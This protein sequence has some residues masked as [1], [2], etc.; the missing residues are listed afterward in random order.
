MKMLVAATFRSYPENT[1]LSFVGRLMQRC[2]RAG[3]FHPEAGKSHLE[4][5]SFRPTFLNFPPRQ[6]ENI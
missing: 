1:H 4:V 3:T 2:N 6:A 5:I